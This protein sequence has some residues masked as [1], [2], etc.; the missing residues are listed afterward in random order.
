MLR[1]LKETLPE[2]GQIS[3]RL[4]EVHLIKLKLKF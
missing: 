2:W 1:Q 4:G 3:E